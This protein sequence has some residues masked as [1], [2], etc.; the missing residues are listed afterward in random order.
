MARREAISW[1]WLEACAMLARA[2]CLR[3]QFF[4]LVEAQSRQPIWEPPVDVF[5]ARGTSSSSLPGLAPESVE[6]RSTR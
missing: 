2:E 4:H 3:S 6:V 5:E 1:M